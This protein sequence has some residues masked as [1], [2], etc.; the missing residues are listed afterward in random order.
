MESGNFFA[1][2]V[3]PA[4]WA[5]LN[6]RFKMFHLQFGDGTF[7]TQDVSLAV[8]GWRLLVCHSNIAIL[9]SAAILI[10]LLRSK[11]ISLKT[12]HLSF[13]GPEPFPG[14][15][16]L[17]FVLSPFPLPLSFCPPFFFPCGFVFPRACFVEFC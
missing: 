14:D 9:I 6:S 17:H 3:S 1:E 7:L 16:P 15:P 8:L 4:V 11:G 5:F 13:S 10:L 12:S 2:D